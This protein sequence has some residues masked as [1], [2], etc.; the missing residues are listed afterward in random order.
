MKFEWDEAKNDENIRKH[1]L[2]F[3]DAHEMFDGP[4][5]ASI[6]DRFDYDEVR[7]NAIGVL[8]NLVVVIVFA[9]VNDD[10]IRVISLR[11]ALKK[12]RE[13][14]YEHLKNRLG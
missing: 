6:D 7:Y 11:R 14:F 1:Y 3:A 9:E 8:G 13:R 10:T 5:L 2:D 4:M 12:E